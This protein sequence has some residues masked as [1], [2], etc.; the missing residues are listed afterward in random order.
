LFAILIQVLEPRM[1]E[2][3]PP[4]APVGLLAAIL[5]AAEDAIVSTTLDGLVTSW[6]RAAERLFGYR[7]EEMLGRPV[8]PIEPPGR[9]GEMT[10]IL[11][12]IAAGE[13][14]T[15]YETERRRKDG[16]IIPVALTASPIRD[17]EGR[18]VGASR[19]TRDITALKDAEA[20][21][22]DGAGQ[23]RA[24]LDTVPDGMIVIDER[25]TIQSF[26]A[27][28]E[29]MFG[30]AAAEVLGRNVSL[31]MPSPYREQHD[32]YLAH[33][34]E[35]GERRIIGL[36]RVV[37][38]RRKDGTSFPIELSVGEVQGGGQRLFTGFL[39][40][41]TERQ[42]TL[43]RVQELQ[44]E[45][46][47]V[48]R[49]TEMGQMVSALAHEVNQPLTAAAN[50]LE[51]GQRLLANLEGAV[52]V[53]PILDHA[54]AQIARAAAIIARLREFVRKGE[55]ARRPERLAAVIEEAAALALIGARERGVEVRMSTAPNLPAV[56]IDKVQI[57]QV[58]VNLMRNAI[59]AMADSARRE[60]TIAT[61]M[62]DGMVVVQIADT[63]PGIAPEVASRL[64]QPFVTTK[65]QG[66]G[67]G[68]WICRA[69]VEGHGGR[70]WTEPNPEGGTI[71]SFSVPIAR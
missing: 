36:A 54:A 34:L 62:A 48:S 29:R 18:I 27:T 4:P 14:I 32:G 44:A 52:R 68:L 24:I 20:A 2:T 28:A 22:R 12:R 38:G 50:Y 56:P 11:A 49:L 42:R 58:A 17:A 59:E 47:H 37:A 9:A 26:S 43:R 65:P 21:R 71:F 69:I 64:F 5:E 55:S 15:Q 53:A 3:E 31:L 67:V 46:A 30:Y 61:G 63:G 41:L 8:A 60:L 51:A 66:M 39:R 35:T 10:R 25:G 70:L 19:I 13:R 40:D 23:L 1:E 45:L 6:N 57:Q 33:Y 16:R 7:A